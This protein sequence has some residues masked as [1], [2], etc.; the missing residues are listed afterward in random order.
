MSDFNFGQ[1][2]QRSQDYY[3][4]FPKVRD[5]ITTALNSGTA[6][7][8]KFPDTYKQRHIGKISSCP[9][10]LTD[11]TPGDVI[12]GIRCHAEDFPI[13]ISHKFCAKQSEPD[14]TIEPKSSAGAT[15]S[16]DNA[17]AEF[18]GPIICG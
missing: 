15:T 12:T 7:L 10:C 1:T 2:V 11:L 18:K 16:T 13:F 17:K 9:V 8:T 5:E 4:Q 14:S 3:Q 6:R